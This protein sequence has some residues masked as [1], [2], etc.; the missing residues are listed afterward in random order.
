MRGRTRRT[1]GAFRSR[2][3]SCSAPGSRTR[4]PVLPAGETV[5]GV[6]RS[7]EPYGVFIELA[8]NLSGL[9]ESARRS[10][11]PARRFPSTSNPSCPSA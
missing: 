3:A 1:R 11:R 2:I 8:P 9:A 5:R 6:V 10:A 4:R 7:V